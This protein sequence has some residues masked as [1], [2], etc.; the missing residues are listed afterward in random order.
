MALVIWHVILLH[1]KTEKKYEVSQK[2]SKKNTELSEL[3][4]KFPPFNGDTK[5]SRIGLLHRNQFAEGIQLTWTIISQ[6]YRKKKDLPKSA[7]DT[8]IYRLSLW[9]KQWNFV[10]WTWKVE[11]ANSSLDALNTFE[12]LPK[13]SSFESIMFS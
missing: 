12:W 13:Q 9:Y 10:L 4:T 2:P 8:I 5:K 6:I 1:T 3:M 11:V 7:N